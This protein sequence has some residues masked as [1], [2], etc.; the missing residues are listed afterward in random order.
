MR[1]EPRCIVYRLGCFK[2]L[3]AY[4][5]T[6]AAFQLLSEHKASHIQQQAMILLL[7]CIQIKFFDVNE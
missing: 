2:A 6:T 7:N 5:R 4:D 1:L 3:P